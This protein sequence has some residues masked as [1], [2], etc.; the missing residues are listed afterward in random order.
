MSR[1]RTSGLPRICLALSLAVSA[2]L[3]TRAETV[4][5]RQHE[6]AYHGFLVIRDQAGATVGSGEVVQA[7]HKGHMSVHLVFRF[8]DGSID[9]ETTD[10]SQDD[11]LHVISDRHIQ[12]GPFF[13]HPIDAF[14][15]VA[16]QQV[17]SVQL[18]KGPE[19]ATSEHIN[20]P[21]DLSN[22]IVL[23]LVKNFQSHG[24]EA[25][26]EKQVSYLAFSP[27]GRLIKLAISNVG[28]QSFKIAGHAFPAD[29]YLIKIDLGGITGVVA[30]LVGKQPS[31]IDV[32]ASAGRIP[33]VVRVDSAL[34]FGGPILSIQLANPHLV[35][36]S[37]RSTPDQASE[38]SPQSSSRPRHGALANFEVLYPIDSRRSE[39]ISSSPSSG[40]GYSY[41]EAALMRLRLL[42]PK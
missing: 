5:V 36:H 42:A 24:L 10:Y 9:D 20:L 39:R 18:D 23:T 13:P 37:T 30:P 4:P 27:K 22:G 35:E 38:H 6:S 25:G 8:K 7:P 21:P 11:T 12:R 16:T 14:I 33:A 1:T 29:H 40:T 28:Q 31:D 19:S 2:S 3:A 32:W 17:K 26:K 41:P 34:Y 15:D